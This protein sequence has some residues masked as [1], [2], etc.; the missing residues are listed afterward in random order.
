[1]LRACA[2]TCVVWH[3]LMEDG[4]QTVARPSTFEKVGLNACEP[5]KSRSLESVGCFTSVNLHEGCFGDLG[6]IIPGRL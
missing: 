1:M 5:L 3:A 2:P 6:I 4:K